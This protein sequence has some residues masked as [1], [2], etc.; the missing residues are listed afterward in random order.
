[1][2]CHSTC[3]LSNR[4]NEEKA[5]VRFVLIKCSCDRFFSEYKCQLTTHQKCQ[6]TTHQKCQLTTR[7]KCQLTTRQKY[8]PMS[9]ISVTL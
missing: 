7:Q 3:T 5:F 6:L 4:E 9:H 1:M 8:Q 2:K